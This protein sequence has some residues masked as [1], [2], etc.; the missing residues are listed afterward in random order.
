[1]NPFIEP[2]HKSQRFFLWLKRIDFFLNNYALKDWTFSYLTQ[3]MFFFFLTWLKE[4]NLLLNIRPSRIEPLFFSMTQRIEPFFLNMIHRIEPFCQIWL[5]EL[6]FLKKKIDS[7]KWTFLKWF[8]ELNPFVK[9]E[10]KKRKKKNRL[11]ELN[12]LKWLKELNPFFFSIWLK[13]LN[14]PFYMSQRLEP[15]H[16]T[17]RLDPFYKV[18]PSRI[19]PFEKYD[20]KKWTSFFCTTHRIEL[21]WICLNELNPFFKCDSNSWTFFEH[22]AKHWTLFLLNVTQSIELELF[23]YD[24]KNWNFSEMTHRIDF[25]LH[26]SKNWTFFCNMTQR[27]EPSFAT[28]LKQLNLL[29]YI[30]Q[31]IEPSFWKTTIQRIELL[32]YTTQRIEPFLNLTQRIEL[33]FANMTQRIELFLFFFKHDSKNWLWKNMT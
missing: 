20:S 22:D 2:F 26:E 30:T 29:F 8:K 27:N 9:F 12:F 4:L 6:N 13:E 3:R 28:W 21:F 16:M 18:W 5:K 24:S 17:Q 31:L 7:K 14:F 11:K 1:M 32:F 23:R 25:F 19:E 15:C 33:F 10:S